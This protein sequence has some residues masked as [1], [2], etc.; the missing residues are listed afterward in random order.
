MIN[1][2]FRYK[3]KFI[4]SP[5]SQFIVKKIKKDDVLGLSIL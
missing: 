3:D 5:Y 2:F 4:F 1:S